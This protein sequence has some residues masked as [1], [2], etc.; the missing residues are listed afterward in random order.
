MSCGK[1][2]LGISANTVGEAAVERVLS[3]VEDG[4][5][6]WICPAPVLMSPFHTAVALRFMILK[7]K[8]ENELNTVLFSTKLIKK[9]N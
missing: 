4:A 5:A 2:L 1:Q 6:G 8:I 3:F 7:F 9:F